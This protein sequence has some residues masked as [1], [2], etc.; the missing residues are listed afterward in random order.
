MGAKFY[1]EVSCIPEVNTSPQQSLGG[2][3]YN[4][5][6]DLGRVPMKMDKPK[7]PVEKLRW[8]ITTIG[9]TG[10]IRLEWVNHVASVPIMV[11]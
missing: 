7:A 4:S 1:D 6:L 9:N 3:I 5:G 11:A 8:S 10:T 2:H